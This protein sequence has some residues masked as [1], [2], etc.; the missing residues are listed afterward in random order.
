VTG[1]GLFLSLFGMLIPKLAFLHWSAD[2]SSTSGTLAREIAHFTLA[3]VILLLV[4]FGERR[5][6]SS[7]GIGTSRWWKALMWGLATFAV[8]MVVAI[9]LAQ[10][11]HY[12]GGAAGKAFEKLPT[13]LMALTVLR[14]GIVEEICYRGYAI[15]RPQ[16]L[17]GSKAVA[18][19]VPLAIFG[20]GHW[21]GGWANILIAVALG[22][23][24]AGFF[25]WRRD[26][27]AN[28]TG[29]FLVDFT[30]NVL[31]RLVR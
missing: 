11:T 20:L 7:I 21:T 27:V 24:L 1:I 31:P 12:N 9:V 30:A 14:A 13:W 3:I 28:M 25:L 19:A 2:P 5:P 26:L 17:T 8:C 6:L 16:E 23:I 10:L 15:T 18:F 29:H 4:R 22:G